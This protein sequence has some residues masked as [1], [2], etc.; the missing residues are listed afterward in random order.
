ME[1]LV[2][3]THKFESRYTDSLIGPYPATRQLYHDRSAI[4]FTSRLSCPMIIFQGLDDPV[5]PPSQSQ[6]MA[7]ALRDSSVPFAYL[8]FE[9][10]QH[11]FR[12]ARNIKRSLEAELFFYGRVMGFVPADQVEP[13]DVENSDFLTRS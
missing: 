1:A 5:V 10:E 2:K 12:K 9:G 8:A 11:G 6:K 4:N 7:D 13:V 3:D